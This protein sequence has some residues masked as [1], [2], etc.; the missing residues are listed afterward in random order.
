VLRNFVEKMVK[1]MAMRQ[2]KKSVIR[3][4]LEDIYE[5]ETDNIEK[6]KELTSAL[7][8]MEERLM[9]KCHFLLSVM[10][11]IPYPV[12]YKSK[13]G[14][15]TAVNEAFAQLAGVSRSDVIGK[16]IC[17]LFTDDVSTLS[18]KEDEIVMRTMRPQEYLLETRKPGGKLHVMIMTK[19]PYTDKN[20][21]FQ[22]II[23][24]SCDITAMAERISAS[25]RYKVLEYSVKRDGKVS[26]AEKAVKEYGGAK[27]EITD[28]DSTETNFFG[29]AVDPRIV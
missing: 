19:M 21:I 7:D 28:T 4:G 22:G 25:G 3:Q 29:E 5:S 16:R 14:T 27:Q 10:D 26:N 9:E 23:G 6:I 18:D 13:D 11:L 12:F 24:I 15:Y 8:V 2:C 17:E 1:K 20:G